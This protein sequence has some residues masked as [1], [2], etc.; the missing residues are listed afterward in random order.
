MLIST[1]FFFL[2]AII[3][4]VSGD[5]PV[6]QWSHRL[7]QLKDKGIKVYVVTIDPSADS[8]EAL[9]AASEE[10]YLFR[11]NPFSGIEEVEPK[12]THAVTQ[13]MF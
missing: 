9:R 5:W 11:T 6:G 13:G 4:V 3:L 7:M 12:I 2:K 8:P 1:L 10:G